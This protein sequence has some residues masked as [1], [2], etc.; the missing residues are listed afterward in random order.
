MIL[1][2]LICFKQVVKVP[3]V[4]TVSTITLKLGLTNCVILYPAQVFLLCR[5]NIPL[6]CDNQHHP[7]LYSPNIKRFW[8]ICSFISL[9]WFCDILRSFVWSQIWL[10]FCTLLHSFSNQ[11]PLVLFNGWMS[12]CIFTE[13]KL[14][15]PDLWAVVVHKNST[16]GNL[17]ITPSDF[18][19]LKYGH[20]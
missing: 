3:T 20:A 17:R 18:S 16:T 1:N 19:F 9:I 8:S 2:L 13:K 10:S 5:L 14:L 6:W 15:L 7:F 4:A 12:L 11:I